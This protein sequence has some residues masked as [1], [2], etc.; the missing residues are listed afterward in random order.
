MRASKISLPSKVEKI[1]KYYLFLGGI[2]RSMKT[3]LQNIRGNVVPPSFPNRKMEQFLSSF[4][5]IE[6]LSCKKE[7]KKKKTKIK[8]EDEQ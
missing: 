7:G 4:A 3:V 1:R 5:E 6:I 8:R 2:A